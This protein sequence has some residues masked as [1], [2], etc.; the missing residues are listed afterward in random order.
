MPVYSS[1][2]LILALE[3]QTEQFLDIAV[4]EWQMLPHSRFAHKAAPEKWSANQCL[5]HLNS[6]GRYYLPELR[7][8]LQK[9]TANPPAVFF[10]S[11]WLGNYFTM[12]MLPKPEGVKAN[13]MK[14]PKDHQPVTN[15]DSFKVIA[16][17][18][19]QQEQLLNL[20]RIAS[21]TDLNKARVPI[22][23]APFIKLKLGDVF[24][25]LVAHNF[26]H[27]LQASR[28]LVTAGEKPR[29]LTELVFDNLAA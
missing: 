23:I 8:A 21:Q 13:K 15:A 29:E 20:L 19:E 3:E 26:R 7:K 24:S 1:K 5:Q 16:E 12:M 22:T 28:A 25:F 4:S 10:R 18:I 11:G 17:F 9:S 2:K 27:V 6:Y 14:A